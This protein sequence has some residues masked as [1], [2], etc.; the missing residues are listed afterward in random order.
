MVKSIH[1]TNKFYMIQCIIIF[2]H[3]FSHKKMIR[4][5]CKYLFRAPRSSNELLLKGIFAM[6][7]LNL[8]EVF[9]LKCKQFMTARSRKNR[10]QEYKKIIPNTR[11]FLSEDIMKKS[12][13]DYFDKNIVMIILR[14]CLDEKEI[15]EKILN[16]NE[17]DENEMKKSF[18]N[19]DSRLKLYWKFAGLMF[20]Q[21]Q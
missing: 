7:T 2:G 11:N 4:L 15:Q 19:C 5:L 12:S 17:N 14:Y 18:V 20:E 3:I 1:H 10:E 16:E 13:S 6:G 8:G 21:I 9:V